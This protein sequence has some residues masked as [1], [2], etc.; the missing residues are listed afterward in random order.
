[1]RLFLSHSTKD[2]A[3]VVKLAAAL[4][5]AEAEPWLCEV[6]IDYGDNF[7]ARIE[8]G[9]SKAELVLLVLSP[10]AVASGWT[11]QEWTSALARQIA[12]KRTRLGVLLLRDCDVP[13]L[14]RTTHRF[15]A[16]PD[17]EGAIR[18]VVEWTARRKLVD[19][20]A[21]GALLPYDPADFVGRGAYFDR[22]HDGLVDRQGV[23]LLHGEPGSGKSTLALKFAW[24]AR[25]AFD[26]VVF[27]TCG[28]R[29]AEEI[30][31]E[32]AG[33]LKLEEVRAAAPEAQLAAAR[34]WLRERLSLLVLDDVWNEDAARLLPG[35]PVSVLVTSR[36][37]NWPWVDGRSREAVESFSPAEVE[38]CFRTYLG[39]AEVARY[40][41]ALMAF[42]ERME[43]LPIAI[44]VAGAMLRDSVDPMEEAVAG[45][46]LARLRT[47]AELLRRAIE[48]QPETERRLLQACAVC[49][50]DGFWL[51]LAGQVAGLDRAEV[52][53]VAGRLVNASLL[54]MV[55]RD[56]RRFQLHGLLREQARA[57]APLADLAERHALALEGIFEDREARWKDCRECLE[58]AIP[59]MEHLW[60]AGARARM[61]R[62]SFWG[63][64]IGK[65]IGELETALRILEREEGF[66]AGREDREAKDSL[67]RSY[68]NRALILQDWGRLEEAMA[69]HKK[70][71]A[72]CQELGNKDSLQISYGNQALILKAWGRLEE[73][74]EL[75]KKQEALCLEL[76]NKD[77]LQASY[78]NQAV[79]LQDWGRLEEAM[80]L[81]KKKEALCLELGDKDGLQASYCGQALILQDWGRLEEAMALHKKQEAL[82]LELGNKDSLQRSYGNQAAILQAW[83]RLEEAMALLKKQEAL[84][85]ELGNK[86]SLQRSYGNQAL[87]LQDWGRLEEAMALHKK[88][89]ALCLE[90]GLRSSLGYC[91]WSWGL[92]ARAQGD[93]VTEREKLR[94]ALDIFTELKMPRERDAVAG[95]IARSSDG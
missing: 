5:V 17:E 1:M 20:G 40:G 60:S 61:G 28:Q 83:G 79:I 9:L 81:H 34:T 62:L 25:D 54:R 49:A 67:Q 66:W 90:L 3:F 87:I 65:T 80:A 57:G 19:R 43:R 10:D 38:E 85:L 58:E 78:G 27:Q 56:R 32:L 39:A 93:R 35:P 51:P 63:F 84:C 16:R 15:D 50:A 91:Y 13:E 72:L 29:P 76:G 71:E 46:G 48:A 92:V 7:V 55:D 23:F 53:A 69:L 64:D 18:A 31:V 73:A 44:A 95:E 36:R 11:R 45:L 33:R 75:H 82:C 21:A 4:R 8:E 30:A 37:K 94:A 70:K 24:Q 52:G 74:M 68:G 41:T 6:D 42:A 2:K 47:V 89:E 22:L 88:K 59:A 26:A 14:L 77:G 86:D 12:E